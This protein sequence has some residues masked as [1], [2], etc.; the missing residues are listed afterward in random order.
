GSGEAVV[1]RLERFKL[2]TNCDFTQL[3]WRVVALRGEDVPTTDELVDVCGGAS[4]R[5]AGSDD[6]SSERGTIAVI[7]NWPVGGGVDVLGPAGAV[8]IPR[9][10]DEGTAGEYDALRIAAGVPMTGVD[11]VVGGIPNEAGRW[12]IDHSV[13]FNKGCYTGQELVARIDSRG[14]NVPRPLRHV[15]FDPATEPAPK[16][17]ADVLDPDGKSVGHLTSVAPAA[18]IAL[19]AVG[20]AV[21]PP[22]AVT[23]A[24]DGHTSAATVQVLPGV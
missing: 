23:V 19:A 12:V 15:T 1:A 9:D 2:R 13:S 14:G 22:A 3:D 24:W 17:G 20:R 10:A 5:P 21:D 8:A 7:A 18:G 4:E 6:A 11:L 16:P